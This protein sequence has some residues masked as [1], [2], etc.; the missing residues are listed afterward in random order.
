M[1]GPAK[2]RLH[3]YEAG[4]LSL[5]LEMGVATKRTCAKPR[6]AL[7]GKQSRRW[8]RSGR[9]GVRRGNGGG[10]GT[11]HGS[12]ASTVPPKMGPTSTGGPWAA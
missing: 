1:N 12:S 5:L 9:G 4:W 6:V 8:N 7:L 11:D 2:N 10:D 3:S